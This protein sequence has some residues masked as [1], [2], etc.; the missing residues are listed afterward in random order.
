[1]KI[2]RADRLIDGTGAPP[3]DEGVLLIDG[4]HIVFAGSSNE[5]QQQTKG[6]EVE[7]LE[8]PGETLLP[9]LIDSH[10]HLSVIPGEGDQI[11][12]LKQGPVPQVLR[13]VGNIRKDL[14]SGVTTMRVMAEE[15]FID[16]EIKK[17]IE[18]GRVPGPR[19]LIS[20]RAIVSSHG[21][22]AAL[23]LTDGA[24][25]IRKRIRENIKAGADLIKV[26]ATGGVSSK[27]T[28]LDFHSYTMEELQAA[29]DEAHRNGKRIAAHAIAGHGL[30][31]CIEAGIDSVEHGSGA[32][33]EDIRLM[34]EKDIWLV[35]TLS[36]LY[37]EDGIEKTDGAVPEIREKLIPARETTR[38]NFERILA[39]NVKYAVGTDSVHG[40][41]WFELAKLVEFGASE[42]DVIR[43]VTLSGAEV[44]GVEDQLGSLQAGKLADVV[45]VRGNPLENIQC[46]KEIHLVMK[47]GQRLD[48]LSE[49]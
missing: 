35:A 6:Q 23:T 22:G 48:H 10:S 20:T 31:Q 42:M 32:T 40:T 33:A 43:A 19:L 30:R 36:I 38:I 25:A 37:H 29:V 26:F 8:L 13:A 14:K 28:S 2:I 39:S 16:V 21:H 41:I 18:T 15:H 46:M 4:Q 49:F 24:D 3:L 47:A 12:Q 7:V 5:A 17:A 9:G 44:C 11:G 27:D 45:S 1:M 34:I